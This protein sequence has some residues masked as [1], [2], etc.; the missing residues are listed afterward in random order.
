MYHPAKAGGFVAPP[1]SLQQPL[2]REMELGWLRSVTKDKTVKREAGRTRQ[3]LARVLREFGF[4]AEAE[5]LKSNRYYQRATFDGCNWDGSCKNPDSDNLPFHFFSW[6]TMG[7]LLKHGFVMT[8]EDTPR[9]YQLHIRS[10]LT[11]PVAARYT[12]GRCCYSYDPSFP[13]NTK[14]STESASSAI[15]GT[16]AAEREMCSL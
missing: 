16:P 11:P 14:V 9:N 6:D 10:A 4:Q 13:E 3:R 1:P 8:A 15:Q 5:D 12:L 2:G 7:K